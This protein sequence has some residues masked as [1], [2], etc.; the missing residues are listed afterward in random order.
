[1]SSSTADEDIVMPSEKVRNNRKRSDAEMEPQPG[2]SGMQQ[3][4][5]SKASIKQE[6][7]SRNVETVE[8]EP[9]PGPS[10]MQQ[11]SGLKYV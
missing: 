3:K 2:P 10:G 7:S 1:M 9:Q 6:N 11:S 8:I 4:K 5:Y